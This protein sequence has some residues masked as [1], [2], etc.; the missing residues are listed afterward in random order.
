MALNARKRQQKVEKRNRKR[1]DRLARRTSAAD[2]GG[3][4]AQLLRVGDRPIVACEATA[5]L[6][7]EGIANV[8]LARDLENG[9]VAFAIVL[10]DAYCLGAKDAT[11]QIVSWSRFHD[12][13]LPRF[14]ANIESEPITPAYARKFVDGAVEYARGLGFSPAH[15][16][17]AA[18]LLF[19]DID[20]NE[21]S[22]TFVFG[23]D[24]KPMY[25]SGPHETPERIRFR[26]NTLME[27]LGPDGFHYIVNPEQFPDI[28]ANLVGE[29]DDDFEA[30]QDEDE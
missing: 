30:A 16:F 22:E 9:Q 4:I 8:L 6:R 29:S 13:I 3:L 1:K 26:M 21:C 23:K 27:R 25:I 24:G 5:T 2:G 28:I 12:E 7:E 10:V 15:D 18:R 11:T 20:P 14:R 19:Q 17:E